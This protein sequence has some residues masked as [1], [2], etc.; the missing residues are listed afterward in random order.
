MSLRITDNGE[1]ITISWS[2]L[3][4]ALASEVGG[5][6]GSL[7]SVLGWYDAKAD[8]GCVM[9][10][11][12]DDSTAFQNLVN[13]VG[14]AGGGAIYLPP[15]VLYFNH[16]GSTQGALYVRYDNITIIGAGRDLTTIKFGPACATNGGLVVQGQYK[17]QLSPVL[18]D[19]MPEWH[20]V[21]YNLTGSYLKGA[22]TLTLA[23]PSDAANLAAGDWIYVK[24]GQTI[25]GSGT[26]TGSGN[27][28]AEINQVLTADAGTGVVNLVW[29]TRKSYAQ[30]Y[31][32]TG[33]TGR[34]STS[35]TADLAPFCI[36]PAN[37][38]IIQNF[39]IRDLTI[40]HSV[41]SGS[42]NIC[43]MQ[44]I[45]R[46]D[47][48]DLRIIGK[49]NFVAGNNLMS[50][51][52]HNLRC[53]STAPT[54]N[55]ISCILTVGRGT[56]D[57]IA[58]MLEATSQGCQTG[59]GFVEGTSGVICTN[60]ILRNCDNGIS[61]SAPIFCQTRARDVII[62][63]GIIVNAGPAG[64]PVVS[65]DSLCPDGGIIDGLIIDGVSQTNAFKIQSPGWRL[66]LNY[67]KSGNI[68]IGGTSVAP[69]FDRGLAYTLTGRFDLAKSIGTPITLGVIP[70][71]ATVIGCT[72]DVTTAFDGSGTKDVNIGYSGLDTAYV[73]SA[74]KKIIDGTAQDWGTAGGKQVTP[75]A[76]W[77][78]DTQTARTVV[79]KYL[80]TS[81]T[82]G[83]ALV[84][85]TFVETQ[86]PT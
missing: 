22:T 8:G 75:G 57:V 59:V 44:T 34:T 3:V 76:Q 31:Y 5:G 46:L 43:H 30:E 1:N 49:N 19:N 28:D 15:G 32:I 29:P 40:D 60:F 11:V 54:T 48:R 23:T 65:V 25:N 69:P 38:L 47:M 64:T 26:S 67:S 16:T 24:T 37:D 41:Q 6:G 17:N 74:A 62:R 12:T 68:L 81:P 45:T 33:G 51:R 72:V 66:G 9:D 42:G 20:S 79:A 52:F 84:T 39:Q 56:T 71:N 78:R 82:L 83:K 58:D 7:R 10:G 13:T 55:N 85:L 53:R 21:F 63:N 27:P 4:A 35:V 73:S 36:V 61:S 18:Q 86:G 80:G 14:A 77:G 70:V 2:Q 50:P